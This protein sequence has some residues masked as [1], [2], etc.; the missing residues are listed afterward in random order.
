MYTF[1]NDNFFFDIFSN[2]Q[3]SY[4]SVKKRGKEKGSSLIS[5]GREEGTSLLFSLTKIRGGSLPFWLGGQLSKAHY[6]MLK[7]S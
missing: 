6:F 4:T 2:A 7:Y 5:F 3:I 1:D